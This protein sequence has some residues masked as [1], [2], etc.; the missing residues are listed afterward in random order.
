MHYKNKKFMNTVISRKIS[1]QVSAA[2]SD[3]SAM[4]SDSV[5]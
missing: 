1:I 2:T 5:G 3:D 4:V